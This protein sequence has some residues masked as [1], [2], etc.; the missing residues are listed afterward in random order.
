MLGVLLILLAAPGAVPEA[1]RLAQEAVAAAESRP[2]AAL[3]QAR[4]ALALTADFEPTAFVEAGRKGEVVEDAYVA[5]RE[6]YRR[7]RARLYRANGLVHL[8]A[9]R[10]LPAVRYLRRAS[11]LDPTSP[12]RAELG[13][14]LARLGRGRE[15]LEVLL[16]GDPSAIPAARLAAA[17][18]AADAAAL[19]SLQAELDRVRVRA[20]T[21]KPALDF[22]DGPFTL[23]GR[24]RLTS[25][26]RP[27]LEAD[28]LTVFYVADA[29]CRTCSA[30]LDQIRRAVP[31]GVPLIVAPAGPEQDQVVR[32]AMRLY[33]YD[34]PILAGPGLAGTL[35]LPAPSAFAVGRHG[36]SGIVARPPLLDTVRV[37]LEILAREDVRETI[38][39][40]AWNHRKVQRE[41]TPAPPALLPEG[42]A[43]G[44]DDPP[45]PAFGEAVAA[46]RDRRY[47]EALRLFE[48]L[49][50][51]GDG[52]LLPP[53]ARL[54]RAL[55]LAGMGQRETAR[56]LL[57]KTGDSRFQ[58]AVDQ[59]LERVAAK[60]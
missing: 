26:A 20:A 7:H 18:A 57:L 53:E 48:G 31:P 37:A 36:F 17:Q 4:R 6:A 3:E 51:Q 42:L 38:P 32:A 10:L 23:T 58:E 29:S 33:R 24:E 49:D 13:S 25:G 21:V 19:P 16:S 59:T 14:A 2:E 55:C 44:E 12:A 8:A 45:P 39:R 35:G 41:G 46:Y 22:R 1:E 11:L 52:W 9:G 43:P 30:D 27:D 5:A 34:W 60:P 54:D 47:R 15:A 56:R 50:A 28:G 40:E